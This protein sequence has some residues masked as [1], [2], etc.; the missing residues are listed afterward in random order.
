VWYA[1]LDT[2][3]RAG[4]HG[5]QRRI[6]NLTSK[7]LHD[8]RLSSPA[9]QRTELLVGEGVNRL[10]L[11]NLSRHRPDGERRRV[12]DDRML[13]KGKTFML[14]APFPTINSVLSNVAEL[15]R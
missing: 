10:R 11:R 9:K 8:G 7:T 4:S 15:R 14:F 6:S 1:S 5:V 2:C 12:T 3:Q 13:W